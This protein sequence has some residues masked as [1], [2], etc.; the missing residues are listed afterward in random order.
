MGEVTG[1]AWCDRTSSPWHGCSNVSP[2]CDHCWAEAGAKRNP[3]TLGV[4]GQDGTRIPS[5][6][7]ADKLRRWNDEAAESKTRLRVFPSVC[8]PFEDFPGLDE[9]RVE[10]FRVLEDTP[11]LD[12][13]V[14]TKRPENILRMVP[15]HW[16]GGGDRPAAMGTGP[17]LPPRWPRN[18]WIG[19]TVESQE[20]DWR[21]LE[22]LKVPAAIRFISY[23]PAL[24]FVNFRTVGTKPSPDGNGLLSTNALADGLIHWIIVGGESGPHARIFKVEHAESVVED[25]SRSK[26]AVFV[27]QFGANAYHHG[28][29]V[30]MK[31]R[32]GADPSEWPVDLRVQKFPA[33]SQ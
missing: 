33:V 24:A 7:N 19:A 1:I 25:C 21:I 8:D 18:V 4:W 16:R 14:L 2:G 12:H 9:L 22:L 6:S 10:W 5:K 3:K 29:R 32:A 30:E 28:Q 23:E 11:H 13:L 20:Q 17:A 26:V 15:P 31:H 27:K